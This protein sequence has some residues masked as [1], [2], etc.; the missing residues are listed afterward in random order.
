MLRRTSFKDYVEYS[1]DEYLRTIV[2]LF[3]SN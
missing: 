1:T 2:D 3:F